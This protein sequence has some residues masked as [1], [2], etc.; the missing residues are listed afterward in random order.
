MRLLFDFITTQHFIGGAAEY[1]RKVFYSLLKESKV[2]TSEITFYGL[3]DSS[4]GK[5]AYDDFSPKALQA[6]GIYVIDIKNHT[7]AEIIQ[8]NKID[9]VFIGA[10]QYWTKYDVKSLT[11]PV[12]CVIH[13]LCDEEYF[14]NKLSH[15]IFF[16]HIIKYMLFKIRILLSGG[17]PRRIKGVECL[18]KTLIS[19]PNAK[20]I[21]VSNFSKYSIKYFYDIP[22]NKI[23]VLY[24]P[25]RISNLNNNIENEVLRELIKSKKRYYLMISANRKNKNAYKTIAAFKRFAEN[26]GYNSLLITVGYPKSEYTNHVVLP[27]LSESDLANA[28]KY[29]YAFIFPSF[30]EG[31]GYPP[32]EAMMYGKPILCSNVTSIPEIVGDASI[33]FSPFYTSDIYRAL[34]SLNELNYNEVAEKSKKRYD[35]IS[36][37]QQKDLQKLLDLILQRNK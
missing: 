35:I 5:Y 25:H 12:I 15:L 31:F 26:D 17:K 8:I 32:L 22:D 19:N 36:L 14:Y 37:K 6:L 30:F 27:Y 10:G 9:K 28:M 29:C 3:I 24:S 11:C 23:S 7:L 18:L 13:D 16:Q 20:I 33:S 2:S 34:C 4:I 21:T 1:I